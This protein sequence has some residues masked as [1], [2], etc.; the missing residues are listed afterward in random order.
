MAGSIHTPEV[1]QIYPAVAANE[2]S[3]YG[4]VADVSAAIAAARELA[5][6]DRNVENIPQ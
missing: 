4:K 2:K 5:R 3:R 6:S 1:D